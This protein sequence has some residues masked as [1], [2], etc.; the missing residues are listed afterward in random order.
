MRCSTPGRR[1]SF[2]R[3]TVLVSVMALFMGLAPAANA[4]IDT[5]DACPSPPS[6]GFTDMSAYPSHIRR[7]VDCLADYGITRGTGPATFSPEFDV[8]RWQMALFLTREARDMGID[9]PSGA[10]QGFTDIGDLPFT[11]RTAINQLVQLGVSE[12]HA[13]D[14]DLK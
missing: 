10:N 8:T 13:V 11:T 7:A 12:V 4:V 9:L 6:A 3:L 1:P 2:A 5:D 14:H